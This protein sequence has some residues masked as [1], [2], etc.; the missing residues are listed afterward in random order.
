MIQ[1]E[2]WTFFFAEN[3][4]FKKTQKSAQIDLG[5]NTSGRYAVNAWE[6]AKLEVLAPLIN[7]LW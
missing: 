3:T 1:K 5:I 7:V 6:G 2:F 4:F